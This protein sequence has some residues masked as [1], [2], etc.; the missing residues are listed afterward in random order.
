M[1]PNTGVM[2]QSPDAYS[3]GN[4]GVALIVV[5]WHNQIQMCYPICQNLREFAWKNLIN[6][7]CTVL[8]QE[9]LTKRS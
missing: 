3:Q 7:R 4:S 9:N 5:E 8:T 1:Q 6:C 2:V